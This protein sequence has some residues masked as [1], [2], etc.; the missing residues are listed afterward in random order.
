[1]SIKDIGFHIVKLL[2][3]KIQ[4]RGVN[5]TPPSSLVADVQTLKQILSED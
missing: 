4:I 2:G 1:M 5:N 3:K